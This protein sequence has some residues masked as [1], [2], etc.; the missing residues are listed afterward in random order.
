M[1]IQMNGYIV[2]DNEAE[3]YDAF[4]IQNMCPEKMRNF[5]SQVPENEELTIEINSVGGDVFSGF[6]MYSVLLGAK[7]RT[8]AE[9]QSISASAATTAMLGCDEV[10]ASPVA[11]I[12]IHLPTTATYGNQKDHKDSI[13]MLDSITDGILNAYILRTGAKASR[14]E[15]RR[16]LENETWLTAPKAKELNLVNSIIGEEGFDPGSVLNCAGT[17]SLKAL[18]GAL[19]GMPNFQEMP[20][21]INRVQAK[22]QENELEAAKARLELEKNRFGGLTQ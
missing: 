20:T 19:N 12:M 10:I 16:K 3:M 8:V 18:A 9:V 4:G 22:Q 11:Q 14:D 21:T 2:S 5:I 6:E 1:R 15:L 13:K 17:E 7:C